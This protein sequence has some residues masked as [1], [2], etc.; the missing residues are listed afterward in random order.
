MYPLSSPRVQI[1]PQSISPKRQFHPSRR[2]GI[3]FM[4]ATCLSG[5]VAF[6]CLVCASFVPLYFS[7]QS[8]TNS[9]PFPFPRQSIPLS[10]IY[11]FPTPL[12]VIGAAW[13][14][15]VKECILSTEFQRRNAIGGTEWAERK[16]H[17]WTVSCEFKGMCG[18]ILF[19]PPLHW[20]WD[21]MVLS[22]KKLQ[23]N[24]ILR[25]RI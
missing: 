11:L 4:F 22:L 2:E 5:A 7:F 20:R 8:Y 19:S 1:S 17:D 16:W 18:G 3:D 21:Q 13:G 12:C 23:Q 10:F 25:F 9:Y 24:E 14:P 6:F 15:S